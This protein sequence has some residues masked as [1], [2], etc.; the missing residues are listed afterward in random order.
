MGPGDGLQGGHKLPG[1]GKGKCTCFENGEKEEVE[2]KLT[3]LE[4]NRKPI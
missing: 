1:A 4:E 3:V 2:K